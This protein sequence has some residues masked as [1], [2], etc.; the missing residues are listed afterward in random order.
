MIFLAV[1]GHGTIFALTGAFA[2][3]IAGVVGIGG[4]IIVVPALYYAFHQMQEIPLIY[5]MHM[6]SGTSLAI[7][8]FTSQASIRAHRRQGAIQWPIFYRLWPGIVTGTILG[9]IFA[10]FLPTSIL[11]FIFGIVLLLIAINMLIHVQINY[12]RRFPRGWVNYVVSLLIGFKSGLLGIG[13]GTVIIPYLNYCG[14]DTHRIPG[15]SS[16]C[17]FTV[18]II[19]T[20][21]FIITG[22]QEAGLPSFCTGY[23]YWPAVIWVAIPSVLFAPVGAHLTYALPVQQL[24]YGFTAILLIAAMDLLI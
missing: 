15:V 10:G 2:G 4:G 1:M 12:P 14:M 19:G 6:A 8:I 18:A 13:G 11:K 7:M 16:L 24:K 23:V 5:E 20:I 22:S 3:L 9:A 21:A 17:T